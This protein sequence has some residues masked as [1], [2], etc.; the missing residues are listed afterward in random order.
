MS[1]KQ[2]YDKCAAFD[3][4]GL[5]PPLRRND[6][7]MKEFISAISITG[8]YSKL[9][10]SKANNINKKYC[11]NCKSFRPHQGQAVDK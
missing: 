4:R 8:R 5:C 7:I 6:K 1:K 3:N 10:F 11:N 2:T 9:N